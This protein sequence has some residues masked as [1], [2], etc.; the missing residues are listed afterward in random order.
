MA[1]FLSALHHLWAKWRVSFGPAA[2]IRRKEWGQIRRDPSTLGLVV[3]LPLALIFLFGSAVSLD[4]NGTQ[5][6][7]VNLD[8]GA[9]ARELAGA[10]MRNPYFTVQEGKALAPME[11][12]LTS[13]EIRALVVIPDGFGRGLVNGHPLNLHMMT[14]GSQPNTAALVA[15]QSN[16]VVQTWAMGRIRERGGMAMPAISLIPRFNF[17]PG[18]ESCFMLVPGAIA[19]VMAM[20]GCML[21]ALVMA[22]EYERGT[23]EG[24]LATPISVPS[25]VFNKLLPYFIM[26]LVSTALCVA[27]VICVYGLPLWGSFLGLLLISS[28]FLIAVLGQ[29]LWISAATKNQFASTQFAL[30]LAFLPSLLLSGFLFEI[31]SMPVAIQ[32]LTYLVP[33]RYLVPPLQ[34]LFLVGDVWSVLLPNVVYL[35]MFGAFFLWRVTKSIT[36]IIA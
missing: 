23:M 25:L 24:M 7:L 12:K 18:L 21:T 28:A 5:M 29:G 14:D 34:S 35:L 36:R 30:L 33:A 2:A 1:Q 6:G 32:Y 9:A 4:A 26:G 27:M 10:F 22:R 8:G 31:D 17:N 16:G 3:V 19:I 15:G 20:I 11:R 13:G